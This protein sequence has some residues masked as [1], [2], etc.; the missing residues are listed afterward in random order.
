M[1]DVWV[2][3]SIA[4]DWHIRFQSFQNCDLHADES[5]HSQY[6][7]KLKVLLSA[8]EANGCG[9]VMPAVSFSCSHEFKCQTAGGS[10]DFC[11]LWLM[12]KKDNKLLTLKQFS[13][14][15]PVC[16][17]DLHHHLLYPQYRSLLWTNQGQLSP[18]QNETCLNALRSLC[19]V[20]WYGQ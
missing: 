2:L 16:G 6:I 14:L 19:L 17:W 9:N 1:C 5:T 15:L 7:P 13:I 8:E 4:A 10:V 11:P 20:H 3:S 12:Q 18:L